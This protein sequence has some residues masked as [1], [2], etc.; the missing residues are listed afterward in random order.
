M[1]LTRTFVETVKLRKII[2]CQKLY[3]F[4]IWSSSLDNGHLHVTHLLLTTVRDGMWAGLLDLGWKCC[5]FYGGRKFHRRR[6]LNKLLLVI[7]FSKLQK[8]SEHSR[9]LCIL[10]EQFAKLYYML[11]HMCFVQVFYRRPIMSH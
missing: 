3:V 2:N 10:Q 1:S 5:H 11:S 4:Y 7:N 9:K 8:D 6:D